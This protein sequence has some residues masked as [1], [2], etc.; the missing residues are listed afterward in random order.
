MESKWATSTTVY[1]ATIELLTNDNNG[2][3]AA[4]AEA[5]KKSIKNYFYGSL[6]DA[7]HD[8]VA[9]RHNAYLLEK[10]IYPTIDKTNGEVIW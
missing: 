9:Y 4:I 7:F 5:I 1:K 10:G 8:R 3:E 2:N 6:H